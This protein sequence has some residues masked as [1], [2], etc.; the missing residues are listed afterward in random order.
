[1][2]LHHAHCHL[3]A[4]GADGMGALTAAALRHR[5]ACSAHKST[6]RAPGPGDT[7]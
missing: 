6:L 7:E 3:E 4:S 5:H 2:D 1:M